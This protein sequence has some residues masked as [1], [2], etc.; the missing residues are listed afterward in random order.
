MSTITSRLYANFIHEKQWCAFTG[1]VRVHIS[2]SQAV[3]SHRLD[4][5]LS[6]LSVSCRK[7]T[8]NL[9]ETFQRRETDR[10]TKSGERE[11]GRD[12][13]EKEG[14]DMNSN[15]SKILKHVVWTGQDFMVIIQSSGSDVSTVTSHG[16]DMYVFDV[17]MRPPTSIR[18][19]AAQTDEQ[20]DGCLRMHMHSILCL[21]FVPQLNSSFFH[22]SQ[23]HT[24]NQAIALYLHGEV[25]L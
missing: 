20:T 1:H 7:I 3:L 25:K 22:T 14:N 23:L 13:E 6:K 8:M 19:F 16:N 4:N 9:D 12:E 5:K 15:N 17:L 21:R 2:L 18:S 11:R 24:S 10:Q